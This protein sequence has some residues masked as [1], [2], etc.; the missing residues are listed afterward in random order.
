MTQDARDDGRLGDE[1][2]QAQPPAPWTRQHIESL[3]IRMAISNA[4]GVGVDEAVLAK[5]L[6]VERIGNPNA[7]AAPTEAVTESGDRKPAFLSEWEDKAN[8][9]QELSLQASWD[10]PFVLEWLTLPPRIADRDLRGV[11]YV[12]REQIGDQPWANGAFD[13]W[14]TPSAKPTGRRSQS[15]SARTGSATRRHC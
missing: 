13:K 14:E 1:R 9:G 8:A 2:D 7:Y 10:D 6:L 4:H 12:S 5:M 11:L 15:R 3:A